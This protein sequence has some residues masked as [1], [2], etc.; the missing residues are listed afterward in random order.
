MSWGKVWVSPKNLRAR[1]L[2]AGA[3]G[4]I[5]PRR[6]RGFVYLTS[7]SGDYQPIATRHEAVLPTENEYIRSLNRFRYS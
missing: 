5:S 1:G 6:V 7:V 4:V 3:D 2:G